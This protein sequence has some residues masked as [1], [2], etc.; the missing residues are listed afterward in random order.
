MYRTLASLLVLLALATAPARAA[1]DADKTFTGSG[2]WMVRAWF[3]TDDAVREVASWGDHFQLDRKLPFLRILADPERLDQLRA[4]GFY[5]EVDAE[6]TALIRHAEEANRLAAEAL[7]RGETPEAGIPGFPCYRTVEETYASAQALVTAHPTLATWSDVGDS[8]DKV[9]AGGA[10]GYDMMVLKLTNSAIPGPKP[11]LFVTSAIHAR[12]YTTAELMTRFAEQLVNGYGIDADATWLLDQE[13][14]HLM[15]QTNPD[16]RKFAEGGQLWR[17][18]TNQNYCGATS[19]SRGADLN[20]NFSFQWNCCG[21]SDSNPCGET[22]H[23]ASPGSEPEVQAVQTYILDHFPDQRANTFPGGAAPPDATGIFLDIH[24]YS[25]LVLWPWGGTGTPTDNAT[26]LTTLGRRLAYFNGYF[27][28]Q[29][30]GLYATD[31]TTIDF[32]YGDRGVAAYT[33]E[34]GNNFFE[35]CSS[36]ESSV[37]PTNLPALFYAAKVVRT[38]YQTPVG[39]DALSV[40]ISPSVIAPGDPVTVT[41]TLNDTRFS[42]ANGTE[43]THP[44]AAAEV[45]MDPPTSANIF[46]DGFES[47]DTS[48]WALTAW[49]VAMT[50]DDG[51]FDETIE[52]ASAALNTST[53]SSGRYLLYVH[54]R[55][56]AGHWGP[57]SAAFLTVIDPATAP[58]VEGTVVETGSGTPLA[59][60]VAVGP[61]L[62]NTDPGTGAFSIQVPEGTFDL[63]A[64]AADHAPQTVSGVT[65]VAHQVLVQDFSLAVFANVFSDDVEAGNPG[66]T[67]QSPWAITTTQS[68]SATHSWTDS[69]AGNYG[70]N[71]DTA[72]TS[73]VIDLSAATGVELSFWTRYATEA[74]YDFCHV[75]V[76]PDNGATWIE[77][78]AYDG[79]Q[80][81]WTQKVF[82]VPQLIG[83]AQAKVRFRLTSDVSQ[84]FDGCYI[85]DVVVRAAN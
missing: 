20:R 73:P 3:G 74:T 55:D 48:H 12:E 66:W 46:A 70:N 56:A 61:Y 83:A 67:A 51:I 57:V 85:D 34:L 42:N 7:A 58:T 26:A 23:G 27:P 6:S 59:A 49:P 37:L 50:A 63:T 47:G 45:S 81:T 8:W 31:G 18:N 33:I 75:A 43:P 11:I 78:A 24:S 5:V 69:P 68:H 71:V 60:T 62:T 29:S 40:V 30:I 16:G 17:K 82:V 44:I 1:A 41:A 35:A 15:L 36:F 53:L 19:T 79:T 39:P 10:A 13:E 38:P 76:S 28:E 21:G 52:P 72:V 80:A 4:L 9:T 54:G 22:F 65:L 32:A 14:I 64:T 2:P 84:T 25:D 77:L